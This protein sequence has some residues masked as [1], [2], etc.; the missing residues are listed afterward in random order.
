MTCDP[1]GSAVNTD[2]ILG[3][4]KVDQFVKILLDIGNTS[5]D[6]DSLGFE[7]MV[8]LAERA[9]GTVGETFDSD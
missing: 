9:G 5:G 7:I 4:G 3:M 2:F 6:T 8:E 1:F